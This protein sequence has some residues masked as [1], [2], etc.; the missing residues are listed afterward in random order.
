[1]SELD[2]LFKPTVESPVAKQNSTSSHEYKPSADKGTNGIY[3]SL[4]R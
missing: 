4:I 1:M 2:D 3:K